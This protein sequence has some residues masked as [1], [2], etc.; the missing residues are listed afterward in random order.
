MAGQEN[1]KGRFR[2]NVLLQLNYY[3]NNV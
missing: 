3:Y 1:R 2:R